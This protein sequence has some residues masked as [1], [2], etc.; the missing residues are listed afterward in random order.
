[1]RWI[2]SISLRRLYWQIYL[3]FIL[4]VVVFA[5]IAGLLWHHSDRAESA[6][7]TLNGVAAIATEIVRG[8]EQSGE[9]EARLKRLG[10][11]TQSSFAL[12][13][14]TGAK[15]FESNTSPVF[16]SRLDSD[17]MGKSEFLG[18]SRRHEDGARGPAVAL[19]LR[20][21]RALL[22]HRR[23]RHGQ[24]FPGTLAASRFGYRYWRLSFGATDHS[25]SREA[26]SFG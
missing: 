7:R 21:G 25:A 8:A 24:G 11:Q 10:T 5:A 15:L 19:A 16:E 3:A 22:V 18:F 23:D 17:L 2:R 13:D 1:M 6:E 20:D 26:D 9:L 14:N 12:Y 4:I